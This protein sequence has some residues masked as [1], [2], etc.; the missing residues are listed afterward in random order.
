VFEQKQDIS[1]LLRFAQFYQ[2]LLQA[3]AGSVVDGAELN[4]GDQSRVATDL[5]GLT[6]IKINSW[7][8]RAHPRDPWLRI[9]KR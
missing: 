2:L 3:Q 6:R 1:D 4:D 7:F 8:I 9:F 5:R